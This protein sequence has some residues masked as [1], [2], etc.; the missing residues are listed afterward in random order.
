[1]N[2]EAEFNTGH[3]SMHIAVH[4]TE[5]LWIFI[6]ANTGYMYVKYKEAKNKL[7]NNEYVEIHENLE[8]VFS[9][10]IPFNFVMGIIS[11]YFGM[12]LKGY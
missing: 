10:A 12:M 7:Q 8:L 11:I 6:T 3:P 9:Y 1:M 4:V 5:A 2:I